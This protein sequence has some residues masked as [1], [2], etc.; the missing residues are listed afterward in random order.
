MLANFDRYDL[1]IQARK[2]KKFRELDD[3]VRV[4][5]FELG[6]KNPNI[7]KA[8]YQK[9]KM[10]RDQ[11]LTDYIDS[12]QPAAPFK[13]FDRTVYQKIDPKTTQKI[14]L[15]LSK[16]PNN[17]FKN[18]VITGP[19]GTGKTYCAALIQHEL[20][21][22]GFKVHLTSTFNLVKRMKDYLFGQDVDVPS[23]FFNS[24]LLIIDDLGAEPTIK[25]SDELL[26]TVINERY[27]NQ[28]PFIITTNLTK[29][30]VSTRYDDRIL[31]RIYDKT[32][33]AILIFNGK[34]LRI[35]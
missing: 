5:A 8:E 7:N 31:G 10:L 2:S 27:S 33:T 23:D 3:K 12:L 15:Y 32:K 13:S 22:K 18:L 6:K 29:D 16:F 11:Q 34:D 19:T 14:D 1:I 35:E 30:Q 24:D 20:T 21:Q 26:H 28:K 4:M 17:K 25:N 9:L